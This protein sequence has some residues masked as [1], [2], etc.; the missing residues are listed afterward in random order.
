MTPEKY[1]SSV[2]IAT[3]RIRYTAQLVETLNSRHSFTKHSF[4]FML[5]F[6]HVNHSA[7]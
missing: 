4:I 1:P 2:R 3:Y 5:A 6:T 7:R